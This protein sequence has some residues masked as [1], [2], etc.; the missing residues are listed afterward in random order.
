LSD[1]KT[2]AIS[3]KLDL[4]HASSNNPIIYT[5]LTSPSTISYHSIIYKK[6]LFPQ[7]PD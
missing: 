7:S 3:P 4:L 2:R 5:N 6:S 1:L